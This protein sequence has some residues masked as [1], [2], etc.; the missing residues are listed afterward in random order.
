MV[1]SANKATALESSKKLVSSTPVPST[2][3]SKKIPTIESAIDTLS[4]FNEKA[5]KLERSSFW[6]WYKR[7]YPVIRDVLVGAARGMMAAPLEE[8]MDSLILTL[9]FF[10]QS[11][12]PIQLGAMCEMYKAWE[13]HLK[14]PHSTVQQF[15]DE[16]RT[17]DTFLDEKRP[18]RGTDPDTNRSVLDAF[19]YGHHAHSTKREEY[20]KARMSWVTG[21]LPSP[22][23]RV[24][25]H[26]DISEEKKARRR[27]WTQ[28]LS[29]SVFLTH[30]HSTT[31]ADVA[32]SKVLSTFVDTISRMRKINEQ[33]LEELKEIRGG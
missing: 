16:E 26:P 18:S 8:Q 11:N 14:L 10:M 15:L 24:H 5:E 25:E 33:A 28:R 9:R 22:A 3:I 6:S 31:T 7:N 29:S 27:L 2:P 12:E 32:F 4:L 23:F 1:R 19:I 30:E 17:F 21:R 20:K 13:T